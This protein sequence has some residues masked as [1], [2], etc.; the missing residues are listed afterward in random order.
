MAFA[1]LATRAAGPVEIDDA[2]SIAT[3]YP[4]FVATLSALGGAVEPRSGSAAAR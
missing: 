2:A 3:S 1:T 4:G